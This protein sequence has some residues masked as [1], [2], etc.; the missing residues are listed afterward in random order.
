MYSEGHE[1]TVV[2]CN[3]VPAVAANK[4]ELRPFCLLKLENVL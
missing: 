2:D 3:L 1:L 4:G